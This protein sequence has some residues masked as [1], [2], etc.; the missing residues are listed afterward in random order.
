MEF[1]PANPA[2]LEGIIACL[3]RSLGETSSPK[4]LSY[5]NW[6]HVDNPF[7]PS[8][9]LIA[10]DNG[11]IIGVRAFMRWSWRWSGKKYNALRAVDTA[12]DPD[13]QGKGI[14]KK[15]T[16]QLL[17]KCAQ[18]GDH[19]IF[20]TPNTQSRPGYLKMGWVEV[21]KLPVRIRIA[22]LIK[23]VR[24]YITGKVNSPDVD[25]VLPIYH[26]P[27]ALKN[28]DD[29]MARYPRPTGI[30]TIK[31]KKYLKWRYV[32]CP[33]Q[34]YYGYLDGYD[35]EQML[36]I[37]YPKVQK[38]GVE[39]RICEVQSNSPLA[40]HKLKR[41]M[42]I[43]GQTFKPAYW[44]VANAG[45]GILTQAIKEAGFG[46]ARRIGPVLTVRYLQDN[47]PVDLKE[48]DPWDATLGDLELF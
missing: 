3:K 7:G 33:I 1:R 28:F 37:F 18:E 34:H 16:M 19:F 9:V 36:M 24:A 20:N 13:Y 11:K 25:P 39:L 41:A 27:T 4:T 15:L 43:I 32:D 10:E 23:M 35:Q 31:N 17:E 21:G 26:L 45:D 29:S 22:S 42:R 40:L 8:P 30:N 44:S 48:I 46:K 12:T 2:D 14:F 5:W 47:L 6:K 38:Y